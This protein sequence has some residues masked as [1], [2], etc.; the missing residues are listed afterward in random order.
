MTVW[1]RAEHFIEAERLLQDLGAYAPE[2]EI[3]IAQVHAT[4]ASVP[5][6]VEEEALQLGD[7][8]DS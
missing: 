6:A 3:A 7:D 2:H 1:T 4:L 5:A 8:E